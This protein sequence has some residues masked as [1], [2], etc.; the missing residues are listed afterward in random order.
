MRF[1]RSYAFASGIASSFFF[2]ASMYG[3]LFFLP[4]FVRN[5]FMTSITSPYGTALSARRKM[6]VSLS[7]FAAASSVLPKNSR[8]TGLSPSASV[9]SDLTVR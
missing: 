3:I 6:R 5:R 1:F 4:Q 8:L 7:P 9:R 2:Y